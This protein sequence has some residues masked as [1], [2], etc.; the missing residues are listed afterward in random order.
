[1]RLTGVIISDN[2]MI[3]GFNENDMKKRIITTQIREKL[4]MVIRAGMDQNVKP[5]ALSGTDCEELIHIGTRQSILPVIHAGLK[6]V[7]AQAEYVKECDRARLLD[8]K[9]YILQNDALNK[10][11]ASLDKEQILYIPLKG[12]VLRYLYPAPELR[13]SNDIDVLVKEDDLENAFAVIE[14]ATDFKMLKKGYHDISMINSQVHLEL[15]FTI[16]EN[17]ESIDRILERAWEYAGPA[18]DGSSRYVFTPEFQVFHVVAHMSHHFLHGGL[19]IR[20]FLDLWLLKNKTEYDEDTVRAMCSECGILKFYEVSCHLAEVW[21]GSSEHT[22]TTRMLEEFCLSG[23]VFGSA[24]FKNAGRQ[25][26]IRGWKYIFSRVFPPAY[27]VKEY[28]RDN[29]GKEH[30]LVYYY[31]KR[32]LSWFGGERRADL[33]K[34]MKMILSG[35]KKYLDTAAELFRRLEL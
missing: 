35:D 12:S 9:H 7:G 34:Q 30:A 15:H 16:K 3:I 22:E 25:R 14:N 4:F 26:K 19:G 21:L 32:L 10:I 33:K 6:K 20:P 28:Y 13:T 11:S 23:G 8:I 18:D 31:G 29:S 17:S 2:E 5:N 24:Q 1:M 27:Q